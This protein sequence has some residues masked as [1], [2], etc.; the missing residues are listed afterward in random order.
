[1]PRCNSMDDNSCCDLHQVLLDKLGDAG[2]IDW[3]RAAVD[4]ASVPA[5]RGECIGPNP[6]DKGKQGTKRSFRPEIPHWQVV[7][8][9]LDGTVQLCTVGS[10]VQLR[11]QL[12]QV[13][14]NY[15]MRNSVAHAP[16]HR[17]YL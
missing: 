4:S 1:V 8:A 2:K 12:L 14:Q 13:I 15:S 17:D 3:S 16:Q 7:T 10:I 11:T 9:N 6:T 5:K